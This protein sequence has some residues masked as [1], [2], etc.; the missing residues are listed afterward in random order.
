MSAISDHVPRAREI[1]PLVYRRNHAWF[2]PTNEIVAL[3]NRC[4]RIP[5]T[6]GFTVGAVGTLAGLA[7]GALVLTFRQP[8]VEFIGL[9]TGQELWDPSVRFLTTLP[10]RTDPWEVLGIVAL[11]LVLSFLATLYPALKAANTDPVQVL[12]YE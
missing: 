3:G 9:V 2:G 6:T 7:L 1:Q 11:A 5:V 4:H 10:S 8:I 12:R